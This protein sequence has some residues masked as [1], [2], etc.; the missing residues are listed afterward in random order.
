[1]SWRNPT[2]VVNFWSD[3]Y[4]VA[5]RWTLIWKKTENKVGFFFLSF[6][7]SFKGDGEFL[8][9][10]YL[11][12]K[13][14]IIYFTTTVHF[15]SILWT[16]SKIYDE[17]FFGTTTRLFLRNRNIWWL[18]QWIVGSFLQQILH[19]LHNQDFVLL[20]LGV[21]YLISFCSYKVYPGSKVF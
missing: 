2:T 18:F 13:D 20:K 3:R 19:N 4:I 6:F 11:C 12:R 7:Y 9:W 21:K 16:L 17:A 15:S 10:I 5:N 1:M 14:Y 8:T